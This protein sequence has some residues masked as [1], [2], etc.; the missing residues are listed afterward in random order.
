[1]NKHVNFIFFK[2]A[3][4]LVQQQGLMKHEI[5]LESLRE[6]EAYQC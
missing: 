2:R 4:V 5:S 6:H 3:Q 1:M